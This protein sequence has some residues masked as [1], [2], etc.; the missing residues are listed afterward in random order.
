MNTHHAIVCIADTLEDSAVPEIYKTQTVDVSHI[1]CDRFSIAD[2]RQL[3]IDAL[4]KP[5]NSNKRVFV[6][7]LKKMPE[8][9]QN[10]L[11]KLFE[12]PPEQTQF[13]L[14]IPQDGILIPT[15]RSRV[16]IENTL[17]SEGGKNI[18]FD[19]FISAA[20]ADR[21]V[22]IADITKKKDLVSI[23]DIVRGVEKYVASN[24]LKHGQTLSTVL[25]VREY[26]KTPGASA[27][28]L[29]EELALS[30]PKI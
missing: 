3:S 9:S 26:I 20:Y 4:Q 28:M 24:P 27:K 22:F 15:L 6:L 13:Y 21:L 11:L 1:N 18:V 30:L 10:A 14:V 2:A 29:L 7:V 5:V 16:T 12:E 25:F 8:D 17:T 19:T 23:E